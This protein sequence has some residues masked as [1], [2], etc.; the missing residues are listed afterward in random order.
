MSADAVQIVYVGHSTVLVSMG[1]T[2]VVTDPLLRPRLLHLRRT[3]AA[4][5][6]ALTDVDAILI[7]HLHFDHV[8]F[9]SL[10][11]LGRE[12]TLVVPR[13]ARAL[14]ERRGFR[15]LVELGRGERHVLG[16]LTVEATPASHP[17]RRRPFG[18][19]AEPVGYVLRGSRSVY[20]AGDTDLFDE[21]SELGPV[22]V[23]LLPIWGWGPGLGPGHLDPRS[24]AEA[25]RR[26][27]P[28]VAIPIHWGT[29]FPAH[30]GLLRVPAFVEAPARLFSE[31]MADVCPES[32]VRVLLPGE[33]TSL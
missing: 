24:A 19:R 17:S 16:G 20:F 21:M 1:G 3:G 27:R 15:S 23:A 8:D 5:A 32:E 7:S 26:L 18:A 4:A 25:A 14:F 10:E 30:S 11:R 6:D 33:S 28:R 22:D 29:Y 2:S 31:R 13:G 12:R 9:P